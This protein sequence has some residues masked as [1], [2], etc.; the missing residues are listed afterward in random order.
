MQ[1]VYAHRF[2]QKS[3]LD[4]FGLDSG[5][6]CR[7]WP[8]LQRHD[9]YG[10]P[11]DAPPRPAHASY[12][13]VSGLHYGYVMAGEVGVVKRE[14]AFSGDVLNTTARIQ[15]KCNELGV[16]VLLSETLVR[17]LPPAIQTSARALGAFLLRGKTDKMVVYTVEQ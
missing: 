13:G 16:D 4:H 5:G 3:S 17:A 8:Y 7:I 11:N 15:S 2:L 6:Y 14:I 12:L 9:R 1:K 10:L